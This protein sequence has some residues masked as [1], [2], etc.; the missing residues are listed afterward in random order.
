MEVIAKAL[1]T[2]ACPGTRVKACWKGVR[3]LGLVPDRAQ[4]A[5]CSLRDGFANADRCVFAV[6]QHAREVAGLRVILQHKRLREQPFRKVKDR[7]CTLA[8]SV[9]GTSVAALRTVPLVQG[10]TRTCVHG[11]PMFFAMKFCHCWRA[12]DF[13]FAFAHHFYLPLALPGHFATRLPEPLLSKRG[14]CIKEL[15]VTTSLLLANARRRG[16]TR[17]GTTHQIQYSWIRCFEYTAGARPI[18][19]YLYGN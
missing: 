14:F 8:A 13:A 15:T 10:L 2:S 12:A 1:P 9:F 17:D 3:G 4:R 16:L 5:L 11:E 18:F 6:E 7:R 19:N